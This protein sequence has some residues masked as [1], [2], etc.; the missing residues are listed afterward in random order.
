MVTA[1]GHIIRTVKDLRT[2]LEI[3][4]EIADGTADAKVTKITEKK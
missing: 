4:I 2:D 1:G 3:R